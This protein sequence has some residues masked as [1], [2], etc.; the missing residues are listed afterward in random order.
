MRSI[1]WHEMKLLYKT[2]LIWTL[3]VGGLCFLCILLFHSMKSEMASM[4]EGFSN[5]GAFADAFGMSQ[6]SIATLEGFYATEVG[7]IHSLGAAM[8]VAIISMVMLSKEED[9]HTSEFLFTLPVSRA[10]VITSKFMAVLINVVLFNVICVGIYALGILLLNE[11]IQFKRFFLYHGMQL[12]MHLEI[13]G[14][15][16]G[17]SAFMKK[18]KLG[19]GLGIVMLFYAYDL[20]ARVIPDLSDYKFISPFSYANAADLFSAGKI[21]TGALVLGMVTM[22]VSVALAYGRYTRRDLV[23]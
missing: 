16:F 23:A 21:E 19:F 3:S 17:L 9:G 13:A 6:L 18:N 14:I 11:E 10:K 8:F 4:A 20:M 12:F 22:V 5:M 15:C 1:V 7:T 2:F